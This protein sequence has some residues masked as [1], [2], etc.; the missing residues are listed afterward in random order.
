MTESGSVERE[1][2]LPAR[3]EEVWA[4]LTENEQASAWLGGQAEIDA[5]PGGAVTV[6]W[7]DGTVSRGLVDVVDRPTRFSFRWSDEGTTVELTLE[8]IDD[9]TRLVVVESGFLLRAQRRHVVSRREVSRGP[10]AEMHGWAVS[11]AA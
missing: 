5:R 8:E 10:W 6:T 1:V 4:A 3:A 9:Q 2:L 11:R 7:E